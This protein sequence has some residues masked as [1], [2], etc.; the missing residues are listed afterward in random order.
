MVVRLVISPALQYSCRIYPYKL[1]EYVKG[2]VLQIQ[3]CR[4]FMTQGNSRISK[5]S[6]R[7]DP[8]LIV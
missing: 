7:E 4:T 3:S 6:P 2:P 1:L 8:V 5:R